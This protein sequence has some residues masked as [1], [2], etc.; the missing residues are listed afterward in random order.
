[1]PR[2]LA[3]S[4]LSNADM[5]K[6]SKNGSDATTAALSVSRAPIRDETWSPVCADQPFF[7]VDDWFI[8]RHADSPPEFPRPFKISPSKFRYNDLA[9]LA[10]LFAAVSRENCLR[11]FRSRNDRR[12]CN[13]ASC[14]GCKS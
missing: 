14:R 2:N 3:G 9:S 6:F 10:V 12:A 4:I 7:S 8:G 13:Q 5:V 11:D 1:M